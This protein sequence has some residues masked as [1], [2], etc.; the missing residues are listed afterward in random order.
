[1]FFSGKKNHFSVKPEYTTVNLKN[2]LLPLALLLPVAVQAQ[3]LS[4]AQIERFKSL[5][6]AQ[7]EA[8]AS[9]YGV[10][11]DSIG[12]GSGSASSNGEQIRNPE[13]VVEKTPAS[14][15]EKEG[16]DEE[17]EETNVETK[18]SSAENEKKTKRL[19]PF[20]Y[21]LFAGSP[22][23]FAPVTSIPVPAEYTIGPG[24]EIRIQMWGKES[25]NLTLTVDRDGTINFP[26]IGPESVAGLTFAELKER[27]GQLV[28]KHFIGLKSSVSLGELR[29]MQIFVV[30]DARTPGAYTVSSLSTI[31]NALFVSGG[32]SRTGTLRN[33][34]LKRN[35]KVVSTLDLYNL[36][37]KGDTS[38]DVRLQAGDVIFI[39]PV[40]ELVGVK[41]EVRRP[42]LYELKGQQT[43]AEVLD[44]A[45]GLTAD[46]YPRRAQMQRVN[47]R[48]ELTMKDLNLTQVQAKQQNVRKGDILTVSSITDLRDGFVS[49]AGEAVRTGRYGWE[50]GLTVADLIG[51]PVTGLTDQA[52]LSYAVLIRETE[53]LTGLKV[54]NFNLKE[55]L[56]NPTS[57]ENLALQARDRVVILND[58]SG[59]SRIDQLNKVVN[60]IR[61]NTGQTVTVRADKQATEAYVT[62]SGAVPRGGRYQWQPGL[63]VSDMLKSE[64]FDL[65]ER[66]DRKYAL[67]ISE[68]DD[69]QFISVA[70]FSPEQAIA[71]PGSEQ[72]LLLSPRDRVLILTTTSASAR[73][74]ALGNINSRL[75]AQ[76]KADEWASVVSIRGPVRFPGT[77][78]LTE[79]ASLADLLAA[80]GGLKENALMK[81]GEIIRYSTTEKGTGE[82]TLIPFSPAKVLAGDENLQLK[83]RDR[84]L[85][86]G[87]PDFAKTRTVTLAGEV[88][89]PGEYTFQDGETLSDVLKRAGGLTDNAFPK[90]AVFTRAKLRQLEAQRLQEAEERL[91]GDLLGVQLEGNDAGGN[92]ADRVEEVEGLLKDV[93]DSRPV[94]RM[95]IDLAAIASGQQH[96][97]VR[98]QD[99]DRLTV[100]EIPQ[101]V[102]VF[103]EVQF[104]TS[105]MHTQGLT[106]DDYLERS[107]GPTR[108]ADESRVYVV[109]ADGSVM[110]PQRS[111]WF[112]GGGSQ[113][114]PGDT[115]IMPIDVDRLN[116]LELWTNVSQIVYQMAL[117]AAAVGNL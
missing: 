2:L 56:D 39:P 8:L 9:Q 85:I 68:S 46:A 77:Y 53:D 59:Q 27:V 19:E 36:L 26:E 1:M 114:E 28:E 20:G 38:G 102:T 49:V 40:G 83:G 107:G 103:G 48:F 92:A 54:Y 18:A 67:R 94:G 45:G 11:L 13:P 93:Q 25:R 17:L 74:E 3:S 105:H 90:G 34:Q 63:R 41:G 29:S 33:I 111:N 88:L 43:V 4:P 44:M 106:V 62:L 113:L 57:E 60:N 70:S 15:A 7:Q 12:G 66:A 21:D 97:P 116:Q 110:M 95:V 86:K 30:G 65:N 112:G 81:E 69:R 24:D 80:T 91:Q 61:N 108:Q 117:G 50:E 109:K 10:D 101:A 78:P 5:P 76:T 31:T 52:D 84:I 115:I 79:N 14:S 64:A 71:E 72:D 16:Q 100:P 58:A 82:T 87:V 104:P 35:G 89:Y 37:L 99:G 23:T 96:Q 73:Q 6:K 42:A 22:S 55:A 98:L 75:S 47:S 32:I 51:D